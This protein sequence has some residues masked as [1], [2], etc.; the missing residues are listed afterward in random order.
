MSSVPP[1]RSLALLAFLL[2]GA[3]AACALAQDKQPE[4]RLGPGD[5]IRIQVYQNPDL[6]LETRVT[7]S[8]SITYPLIGLLRIGGLTFA[9]AEQTIASALRAGNFVQNPQVN[10]SVLTMRGNHVSVL[11]QVNKPGR[12]LLETVNIRA[13]EM[14]AIAGGIASGGADIAVLTG[15]R[16]GRLFRAEIEIADVFLNNRLDNDPVVA[17]GDVIYVHRAPVFYI[18]GEV[19][20][21]GSYRVE[22]G[23]T[24]RQALAQA[25][26]PTSRGTERGLTLHRRGA[27]GA[28]EDS[29]PAPDERVQ[30]DDVLYVRESLF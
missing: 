24:F 15:V 20:K 4:Y 18:Y 2:G 27:R 25:G 8:G 26:G 7:E 5:S 1:R 22:R 14:L 17:G 23:M 28:V 3:L 21:P 10:I 6:A 30:P 11:G 9:E 29:S 12:F 13:S 19:Q 16:A